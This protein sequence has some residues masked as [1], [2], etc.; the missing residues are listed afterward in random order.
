MTKEEHHV[1]EVGDLVNDQ[2]NE[3]KAIIE[4][5][6]TTYIFMHLCDTLPIA[7][8]SGPLQWKKG[9]KSSQPFYIFDKYHY[10]FQP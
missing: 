4:V 9:E 1:F 10:I 7:S 3:L 8:S 6:K 5:S 2:K